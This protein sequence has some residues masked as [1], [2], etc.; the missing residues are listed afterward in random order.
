MKEHKSSYILYT[1]KK[2][3]SSATVVIPLN[4]WSKNECT[5]N[6]TLQHNSCTQ[7]A[8]LNREPL[9]P[10]WLLPGHTVENSSH[11]NWAC[12]ENQPIPVLHP[13]L[14]ACPCIVNESQSPAGGSHMTTRQAPACTVCSNAAWH[15]KTSPDI[16]VILSCLGTICKRNLI[17]KCWFI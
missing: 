11:S 12:S 6:N 14:R 1:H 17:N 8:P 5:D 16:T 3:H 15:F 2:I 13:S 4:T 9:P 10:L 7:A